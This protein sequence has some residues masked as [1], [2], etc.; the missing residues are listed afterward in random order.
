MRKIRKVILILTKCYNGYKDVRIFIFEE[1]G[2]KT[3]NGTS[4]KTIH[5]S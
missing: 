3:G 4:T 2:N 1:F 5:V